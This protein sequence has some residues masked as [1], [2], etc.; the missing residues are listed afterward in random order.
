P[1]SAIH[2]QK[3]SITGS[4]AHH[5]V[6]VLR[7]KIGDTFEATD[8]QN[9]RLLLVIRSLTKNKV[10]C[11]IQKTY[12]LQE[13]TLS[14]RLFQ[15]IPKASAWEQ[16]ITMACE[17]G[18]NEVF[19]VLSDR[20]LYPHDIVG[21]IKPRWLRIA[22]E[23]AKKTGRLSTMTIHPIVLWEDIPSHLEEHSLKIMP[24]EGEK[25]KSLYNLLEAQQSP[26]T[27]E[28]LVGPEG[29]FSLEEAEEATSWGFHTVS[30]GVRILTTPTAVITTLANIY[31]SLDR[32][33]N[34]HPQ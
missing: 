22:E 31:Y 25:E 34:S 14:V 9:R 12:S 17:L 28:L 4:D 24:W 30:L 3:V 13:R 2:G 7:K 1:L 10:V 15:A 20:T 6:H 23:T 18:V 21:T 27:I 26:K 11:S 33:E 32:F 8:G 5:L 29:G 16:I 19:P